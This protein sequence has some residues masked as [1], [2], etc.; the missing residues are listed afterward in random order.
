[1]TTLRPGVSVIV[2]FAGPQDELEEMLRRLGR[3]RVGPD[4]ELLLVD[5]RPVH[6]PPAG[7][8]APGVGVLHAGEVGSSWHARG[9]GV[10][11]TRAEWI[12]FI[13]A[14]TAPPADL[15]DRYFEPLPEADVGI[16]AG[17]VHDWR[18]AETRCARYVSAR[19]KMDQEITLSYP[20]RPYAQ[21][22]N[23]LVRRVAF[24]GIGG[25]LTYALSAG[26]ADLCWRLQEAGWR[27]ESRPQAYVD[28][29]NRAH[30]YDLFRQLA[31]HGAGLAWLEER[32]AGSAPGPTP[33]DLVRRV[34]HYLLAAARAGRP[35][36]ALF[37]LVDLV[38]LYARDAGRLHYHRS[39]EHSASP[40]H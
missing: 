16:L 20:Y 14:D 26:D 35:E 33:R 37:A 34:P 10:A 5:N 31:R 40:A 9:A 28:H 7:V 6:V 25:F 38:C 12:L 39:G 2:P 29:E 22:A 4:D 18:T 13:D 24:E 32:Y 3:L 36:E 27:L 15:L 23:C 17:G 1:M 19:R 21:T 11:A 30:F 8:L